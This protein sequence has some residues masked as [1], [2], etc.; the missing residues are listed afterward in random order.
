MSRFL[1]GCPVF[2]RPM[3]VIWIICSLIV[4]LLPGISIAASSYMMHAD[5]SGM[6]W[7][8]HFTGFLLRGILW[9]L[10]GG[11]TAWLLAT[12]YNKLL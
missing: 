2:F 1:C 3:A 5:F 7:S 6:N 9:I 12:I 4:V 11:A 8:M 10:T